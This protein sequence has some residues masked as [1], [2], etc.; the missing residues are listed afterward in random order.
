VFHS[1]LMICAIT[2]VM[3]MYP[4]K[5][6]CEVVYALQESLSIWAADQLLTIPQPMSVES[7][8][9]KVGV[10]WDACTAST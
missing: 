7:L 9:L 4:V 6:L 3:D 2:R 8:L 1:V 5:E 10:F